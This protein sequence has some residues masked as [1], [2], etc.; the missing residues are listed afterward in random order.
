MRLHRLSSATVAVLMLL[1]AGCTSSSPAVTAGGM[2]YS[3][4]LG[5]AWSAKSTLPLPSG[6]DSLQK[7]S[8]TSFAVD[9]SHS[10]TLYAGSATAGIFMSLNGGDSWSRPEDSEATQGAILDIAVSHSDVCT[11]Y[12]LKADR[13]M[14]TDTCGRLFNH[15]IYVEGRAREALSA[16]AI[17]PK[18]DAVVYLGTTAGEVMK[19]AD[20]GAT[21]RTVYNV[22]DAVSD[23]L[24]SAGSSGT[25]IMGGQRTGTYRSVNA[26]ETWE[27]QEDA[28]EDFKNADRVYA[29]AQNG[30]GK[31][32]LAASRYGILTSYD[33]GATWE[34]VSL[35][36]DAGDV[37]IQAISAHQTI[38]DTFAYATDSALYVTQDSGVTWTTHDLPTSLTP[39]AL[40]L[41]EDGLWLGVR[42]KEE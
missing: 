20:G 7:I 32:M 18:N 42:A 36:T 5:Q 25:V 39:S 34:S 11:F 14:K 27:S 6:V 8:M 19:S 24:V 31:R 3:S 12:V 13:L 23:L 37:T 15:E 4:N 17:D 26:G 33:E 21:W 22:N 41:S 1:G 16:M 29:F 30:D 35:L 2:W 38:S 28:L 9:P 40:N 10:D